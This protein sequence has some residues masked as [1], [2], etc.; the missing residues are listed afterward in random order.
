MGKF[1]YKGFAKIGEVGRSGA[2]FIMG[3]NLRRRTP[4]PKKADEPDE[5][6]EN[7]PKKSE[8]QPTWWREGSGFGR[9]RFHAPNMHL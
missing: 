3:R 1:T 2:G 7:P 4:D 8:D 6:G 9:G 5:K